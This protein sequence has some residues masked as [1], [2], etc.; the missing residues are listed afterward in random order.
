[1]ST[2]RDPPPSAP[3]FRLASAFGVLLRV[4]VRVLLL[5]IIVFC[6]TL[7]VLRH[8]VLPD[9]D[10]HRERITRLLENQIGQPVEIGRLAAGWDGWNPRLDI[11]DLHVVDG[12]SHALLLDLPEVHLTVSWVSLLFVDLRF[13]E[14]VLER[15]QFALRRDA[16]GMLHLVGLTLDPA[17]RRNDTGPAD[18]LLRQRRIVIHDAAMTWFDEERGAPPLDLRHVEFRLESRFGRHRF[19]LTGTPPAEMS[20][21]LDL[22]GELTASSVSEWRAASGRLYV[23]LDYADV[24]A[25]RR[26]LPLP[27]PIKSG[28]GALRTWFD[29]AQG[30]P[31]QVIADVVL[32]DV[33]AKLAPDVPD[34]V[35]SRLEGRVGWRSDASQSEYFTEQLA[36][37]APGDVRV[38]PTD[39]HLTLQEGVNGKTPGG[40]MEFNNLQLGPLTA[41]AAH[42]PLP[43]TWRRK[44][45]A[46]APR[47]TLFQGLLEWRGEA[48]EFASFAARG[49]FV[50]LGL[51]AQEEM[52]GI[53]GLTGSFDATQLGGT[54]RVQSHALGFAMPRLFAEPIAFDNAQARIGWS[55]ERGEYAISFE[56]LVFSNPH[57]SGN[58][59]GTYRTAADGPGTIDLNVQLSR[60]D[61]AQVYRYLPLTLSAGVRDWVKRSLVGGTATE[62]RFR[63][64]G[65]LADFPFSNGKGG[66]FLVTSK[67]QGVTFDYA[68]HWPAFS[69]VEGEVRFEGTRMSVEVRRGR[70][71]S[72]NLN[73]AKAT[74]ADLRA[75]APVLHVEGEAAGPTE[76]MLQYIRESPIGA[77]TGDFTAGA[78]ASGSGKLALQLDLP[79]GKW[80]ASKAA[81]E[82]T[83]AANRLKIASDLP[84]L[85][86]LNGKLAFTNHDLHAQQLTAELLGGPARFNIESRGEDVHIAGQ[87]SADL[88]QLRVEYPKHVSARHIS[89][90]TAWQMAVVARPALSTWMLETNL[91]GAAI[92]LPSPMAK[93]PAE[94]VPLQIERSANESGYDTI[95]IRYGSIGRLVLQRKLSGGQAAIERGLLALGGAQGEP[96]R[97]GVWVRGSV[98]ALNVDGWLALKQEGEASGLADATPVNGVDLRVQT[99]DVFGRRF[100]ELHIGATRNPAGW[101]MDLRGRELAGAARW[102]GAAPAHPNG[103]V[104]A[105][106]QRFA[107]PGA[108]PAQE[109]PAEASP[110]RPVSASVANSWPQIDLVADSFVLKE[111]DL[112]K[113]E[114]TAQPRGA[115]WQ[116]E[117]LQLVNDDG[118]LA[119]EGWWRAGRAQ[120]TKLDATLDISD[121]GKYLARFGVPGAIRGAPTK[122][123][124]NLAWDGGPEAFDYPTLSGKL[125]IEAGPGSFIKLDPGAGKLLGVLSLQSLRRRLSFDYQDLFGEGFAF[126]ELT[127]D[128][129]IEN[130]VMKS[131]NVR[132]VGPAASVT[133][134]GETNLARETQ[135][136]KIHVQPT[137]SGSVS[138]GAAA[139]MLANPIIGAAIGAGTLLAQKIMQ[140]P[141]EQIFSNDYVIGGTWSEP[142]V[143]RA[144]RAAAAGPAVPSG[145]AG[146]KVQ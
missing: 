49:R 141:L 75:P 46:Y 5:A 125:G 12:K 79:L 48:T 34:L 87:G 62:S 39:F 85:R 120:Q 27:V 127:G 53:A 7:L 143:E 98:D 123:R 92:D 144:S 99:L 135:Q 128:V 17:Q 68:E 81:G 13:K 114:L 131:E 9:I 140:D 103:Y 84:A 101:Q 25:W 138:M 124:A 52:P 94:T 142:T 130:G 4:G 57:V 11:T 78:E 59:N 50:D 122:V 80:A 16:Q 117:R 15:P 116:I 83:F 45:A 63:I 35:L 2:L 6:S 55:L 110:N 88:A 73:R 26:W 22:R 107:T 129:L 93:L 24:D 56:Q 28:K 119:A 111:R 41:M 76:D 60:A 113:L 71:F 133:I 77:W 3:A 47:G 14:L 30:E 72:F 31:R 33:Q 61:A 19:G 43:E 86:E 64:S 139:L 66:Q 134:A 89:G 21:P 115:D 132:I 29:F 1:M 137:L 136:L 82:Y 112:G 38:D 91:K 105:R 97:P 74:I 67:G 23:R 118:K 100:N 104:S 106:L 58:A 37:T 70:V 126:D 65:D 121:A 109:K 40:R 18:W 10:S 8:I 146:S 69:D 54:V 145:T 90:T 44:L 32:T 20:A 42:L 96:D 95:A 51:A 102:Q 36:F 108:A